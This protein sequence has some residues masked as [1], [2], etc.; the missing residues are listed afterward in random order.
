MPPHLHPQRGSS[1]APAGRALPRAWSKSSAVSSGINTERRR[2]DEPLRANEQ[3]L[4]MPRLFGY[5]ARLNE[6]LIRVYQ[7]EFVSA[8]P[9]TPFWFRVCPN[10]RRT[11]RSGSVHY[12]LAF[13]HVALGFRCL[14]IDDFGAARVRL[15]YLNRALTCTI[16]GLGIPVRD[17]LLF[18]CANV[19]FRRRA[20]SG[21]L[22]PEYG[23]SEYER[24]HKAR[25]YARDDAHDESA[26]VHYPKC[27]RPRLDQEPGPRVQSS[28]DVHFDGGAFVRPPPDWLPVVLGQPPGPLPPPLLPPPPPPPLLPPPPPPLLP[29]L[30]LGPFDWGSAPRPRPRDATARND[31][32]VQC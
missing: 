15:R 13:P 8:E 16:Q 11:I 20:K 31:R 5:G 23:A 32:P 24:C 26:K 14:D 3:A 2:H 17:A 29:L 28:R 25:G 7:V 21:G 19:S 22:M 12:G 18:P 1:R 9:C 4:M 27:K 6:D 10:Q 30:M